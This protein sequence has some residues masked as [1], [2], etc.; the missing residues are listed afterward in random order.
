MDGYLAD[1]DLKLVASSSSISL[2]YPLYLLAFRI[3]E[4]LLHIRNVP[5]PQTYETEQRAKIIEL[6]F[7]QAY[8]G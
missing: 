8:I 6:C 4:G 5:H 1:L 3:H 2:Y 7:S